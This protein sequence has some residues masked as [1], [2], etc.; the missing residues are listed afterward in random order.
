[1]REDAPKYRAAGSSSLAP[2]ELAPLD[3]VKTRLGDWDDIPETS[4]AA[5]AP[6]AR[7]ARQRDGGGV[8]IRLDAEV[9]AWLCAKGPGYRTEI[10]RILRE[11][12]EAETRA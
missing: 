11:K 3:A 12:M 9:L 1:M 7:Q 5:G 6:A 4:D 2:P 8:S 10:N